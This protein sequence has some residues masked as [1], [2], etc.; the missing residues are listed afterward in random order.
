MTQKK[1]LFSLLFALW[2]ASSLVFAHTVI[3]DQATEGTSLYTGFDITH[4]CGAGDKESLP[5]ISQSVAFPTGPNSVVARVDT[6]EAIGL[7]NVLIGGAHANGLINPTIIQNR[8][9]FNVTEELKD[10]TGVVRGVHYTD[11]ELQ[12]DLDGVLPFRVSGVTFVEE[13]CATKVMARIGIANWCHHK[14]GERRADIW[15]GRLTPVFNDEQVVSVGFWPTLV[16]NRDLTANPLP[17]NCGEGYEV[18]VEPS[19]E[20]IDQYLPLPGFISGI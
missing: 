20:D 8:D 9:V 13:S 16:I 1:T 12:A 11:G 18:A 17:E 3:T 7:G 5:V 14:A 2:S 6:G 10:E 19:D 4:G 15:I